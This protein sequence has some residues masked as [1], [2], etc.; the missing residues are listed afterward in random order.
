MF[1]KKIVNVLILLSLLTTPAESYQMR[2]WEDVNGL[3]IK[4]KFIRNIW[5]D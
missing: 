1:I 5:V 3:Q 4:G 2:V